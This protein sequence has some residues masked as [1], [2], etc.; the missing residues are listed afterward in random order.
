MLPFGCGHKPFLGPRCAFNCPLRA[1]F[2]GAVQCA[3]QLI[4]CGALVAVQ[5]VARCADN[6]GLYFAVVVVDH[7]KPAVRVEQ[8]SGKFLALGGDVIGQVVIPPASCRV[9]I[10]GGL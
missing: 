4:A 9:P 7:G 8:H 2:R 3:V 10:R 1:V 6:S 5:G